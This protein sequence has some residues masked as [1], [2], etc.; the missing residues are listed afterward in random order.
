MEGVS[1]TALQGNAEW[2]TGCNAP[3][4]STWPR[5]KWAA[6]AADANSRRTH[7]QWAGPASLP[8]AAADLQPV[9]LVLVKADHQRIVLQLEG[10]QRGGALQHTG[11]SHNKIVPGHRKGHTR[12]ACACSPLRTAQPTSTQAASSS[13]QEHDTRRSQ[14]KSRIGLLT[15][16]GSS[17]A[18]PSMP[19]SPVASPCEDQS[20]GHTHECKLATA[21]RHEHSMSTAACGSQHG[22]ACTACATA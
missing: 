17:I 13:H 6:V 22:T 7:R 19:I 4:Q 2:G 10:L 14:A 1:Y 12:A 18:V 20:R 9:G 15:S 8:V 16:S 5:D 11:G 3:Q 21:P